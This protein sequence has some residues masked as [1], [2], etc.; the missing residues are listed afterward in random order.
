MDFIK[1][2][3]LDRSCLAELFSKVL[4]KVLSVVRFFA[5]LIC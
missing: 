2:H 3:L 1:V 4:S 5:E